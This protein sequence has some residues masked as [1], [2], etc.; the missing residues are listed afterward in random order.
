[1]PTDEAI[2][3]RR[4]YAAS[5]NFV[6]EWVGHIYD[7]LVER[8][9]LERTFIIWT[10][11]H[12]DGQG[13]MYHWRKGYPYE[14]SAHVPM[15]LRWPESWAVAQSTPIIAR[16]TK[17]L[18]PIVTELR[19]V[20]HTMIDAAGVAH[21]GSLVPARNS[22]DAHAFAPEDGKSMLC[23]LK[24]PTGVADCDYPPN[25]GPWRRWID[26]EH[27]TC[28]NMSN[29][30]S[31]LTDG[32]M[33]YIY[34]AWA[35]DE[36]LFNLTADP[37]EM[38]EV[39]E[40]PQYAAELGKWR[41]RM[42]QQFENELR[43]DTWVK[44]GKLIKRT[45]AQGYSPNYP[46]APSPSPPVFPTPQAGDHVI[47]AKNGGTAPPGCGTNDCWTDVN[48]SLQVMDNTS[49]CL[50]ISVGN[51]SMLEVGLCDNSAAAQKFTYAGDAMPDLHDSVSKALSPIKHAP[52]NRCVTASKTAGARPTLVDCQGGADQMWLL[53]SSGRFCASQDGGLCLR[54][55]AVER[56]VL[57]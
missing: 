13:D 52:S 39:S 11:D 9:L 46:H 21:N 32:Q 1:M 43:G 50:S 35:D 2:L 49:L 25:P 17:I 15:L 53:G 19:D 5:V 40:L 24:D 4:A 31:A 44:N 30:W 41:S 42:V 45:K 14:F 33:K 7:S 34:R 54:V 18:P 28:Y 29:H 27:S 6:D 20:F 3:S 10:S 47:M 26:M 37:S 38:V 57:V 8:H 12:G 48:M 16:G 23:L 51:D 36:Q 22:G 56:F 55:D